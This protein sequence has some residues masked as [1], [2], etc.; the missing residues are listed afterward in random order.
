LQGIN[1]NEYLQDVLQT[2]PDQPINKLKE[3][4]PPYRKKATMTPALK[5]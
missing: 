5:L 4:L 3:L 2:L 1:V